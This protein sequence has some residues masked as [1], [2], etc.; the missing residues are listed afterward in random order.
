[1]KILGKN[2]ENFSKIENKNFGLSFFSFQMNAKNR[3]VIS[4]TVR[5]FI[6]NGS[7]YFFLGQPPL[8][9]TITEIIG[10]IEKQFFAFNC[11]LKKLN[12]EILLS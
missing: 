6:S 9:M 1:L 12:G 7:R 4:H 5:L 3:F 8:V 2:L 10:D 11:Q